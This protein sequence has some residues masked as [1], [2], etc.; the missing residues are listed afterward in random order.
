MNV[1]PFAI[2][3]FALVHG[4]LNFYIGWHLGDTAGLGAI[5]IKLGILDYFLV[6]GPVIQGRLGWPPSCPAASAPT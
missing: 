2:L 3:I 4:S 5:I 1:I 6:G